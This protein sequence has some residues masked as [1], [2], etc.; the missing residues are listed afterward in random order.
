M[1]VIID[2]IKRWEVEDHTF[3]LA[4]VDKVGGKVFC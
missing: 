4:F 2:Q 1:V 3:G